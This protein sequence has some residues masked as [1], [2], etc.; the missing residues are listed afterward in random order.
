MARA[1]VELAEYVG[2][3]SIAGQIVLREKISLADIAAMAGVARENV[4]RVMSEWRRL[5]LITG[6]THYYCLNDIA[7]LTREAECKP[8]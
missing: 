7:A 4:S 8:D 2:T 5:N 6:S 3:P 1:L